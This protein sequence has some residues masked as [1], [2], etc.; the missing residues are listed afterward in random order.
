LA[1]RNKVAQVKC[2][3]RKEA[4]LVDGAHIKSFML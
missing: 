2:D 4:R 1:I 3:A